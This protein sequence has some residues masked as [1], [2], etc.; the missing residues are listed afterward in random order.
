[1]VS[2]LQVGGGPRVNLVMIRF[3]GEDHKK[4]AA[5]QGRCKVCKKNCCYMCAK[6][7]VRL[8]YDRGSKCHVIYQMRSELSQ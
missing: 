6:C 7:N 2:R 4:V 5:S 8:H 1:M 3:D